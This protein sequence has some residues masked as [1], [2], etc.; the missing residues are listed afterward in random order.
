MLKAYK[1]FLFSGDLFKIVL[2]ATSQTL[3]FIPTFYLT[4]TKVSFSTTQCY[5]E[6]AL[7]GAQEWDIR[8]RHIFTES[9][10]E[11]ESPNDAGINPSV[12][13][14]VQGSIRLFGFF[15]A[16]PAVQCPVILAFL[17]SFRSLKIQKLKKEK[18][19]KNLLLVGFPKKLP[20]N[21]VGLSRNRKNVF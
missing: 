15:W 9:E 6:G 11:S 13:I 8:D 14:L 5:P 10:S 3:A 19:T 1:F 21:F 2:T 7:K 12:H 18:S 17:W 20:I 4:G 16:V